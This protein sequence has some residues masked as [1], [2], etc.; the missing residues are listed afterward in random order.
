MSFRLNVEYTTICIGPITRFSLF[1]IFPLPLFS[2]LP[3]PTTAIISTLFICQHIIATRESPASSGKSDLSAAVAEWRELKQKLAAEGFVFVKKR[4]RE[5]R[6]E[7]VGEERSGNWKV[8]EEVGEGQRKEEESV[9]DGVSRTLKVLLPDLAL[10]Q[11][12]EN[13]EDDGVVGMRVRGRAGGVEGIEGVAGEADVGSYGV[14]DVGSLGLAEMERGDEAVD[15][16]RNV[17]DFRFYSNSAPVSIQRRVFSAYKITIIHFY[18]NPNY[19]S[20][21]HPLNVQTVHV[22]IYILN[23]FHSTY[24]EKK[25]K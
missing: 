6:G 9:A 5:E 15:L 18:H 19:P 7:E 17:D 11:L 8:E 12:G 22:Q 14:A 24:N 2:S 21:L 16:H 20:P 13:A 25:M 1:P 3:P 10:N 23:V 4:T